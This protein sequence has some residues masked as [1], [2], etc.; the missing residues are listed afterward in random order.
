MNKAMFF[1]TKNQKNLVLVL[2]AGGY[3]CKMVGVNGVKVYIGTT[4]YQEFKM[5]MNEVMSIARK[6]GA[7]FLGY[8]G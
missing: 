1:K 4:G 7:R 5:L 2:N 8:A 6:F 3:E